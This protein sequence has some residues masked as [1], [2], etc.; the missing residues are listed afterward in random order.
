MLLSYVVKTN[1]Q[2]ELQK[3]Y[4]ETYDAE[5]PV[6]EKEALQ[7]EMLQK[8]GNVLI[9]TDMYARTQ[10]ISKRAEQL[11]PTILQDS[12]ELQ[13]L[14]NSTAMIDMIVNEQA[15]QGNPNARYLGS[16]ISI[17]GKYASDSFR[18]PL[19]EKTFYQIDKMDISE[20]AKKVL[21]TGV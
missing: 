20:S 11:F 14:V 18:L 5:I 4:G 1:Y 7:K 2:K 9:N 8:Y 19:L 21:K 15:K 10:F 3:R 6:S 13:K 16:V 12:P 17:A